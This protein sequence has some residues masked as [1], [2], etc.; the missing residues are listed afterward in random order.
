V[1]RPAGVKV[2]VTSLVALVLIGATLVPPGTAHVSPSATHNWRR[3]YKP[4]AKKIFFTKTRANAR[5]VNVGEQASDAALLDGMDSSRVRDDR[6]PPQRRRHHV[7]HR[8]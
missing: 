8:R 7:G 5:F 2:V 3:H 4:L 6:P 1:T